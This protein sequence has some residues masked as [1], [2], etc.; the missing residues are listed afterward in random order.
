VATH[1]DESYGGEALL[2]SSGDS[3]LSS[4][5]G[6]VRLRSLGEDGNRQIDEDE[7]GVG[8]EVFKGVEDGRR[9]PALQ[10]GYP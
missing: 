4:A 1:R 2:R 3:V 10:A 7:I 6:G 9:P 5:E 8:R